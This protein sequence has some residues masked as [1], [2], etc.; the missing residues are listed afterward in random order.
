MGKPKLRAKD[1]DGSWI[2]SQ[3]SKELANLLW[4]SRLKSLFNKWPAHKSPMIQYQEALL[5]RLIAISSTLWAFRFLLFSQIHICWNSCFSEYSYPIVLRF[6]HRK[7]S[8]FEIRAWKKLD[9]WIRK[10][11]NIRILFTHREFQQILF[12][13][14]VCLGSFMLYGYIDGCRI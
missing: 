11:R 12:P 4:P 6:V 1:I 10:G 3:F 13:Y 14:S 2:P 5:Q 8:C 9:S 7:I